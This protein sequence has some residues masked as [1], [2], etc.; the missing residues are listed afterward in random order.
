VTIYNNG[1]GYKDGYRVRSGGA[2]A[3]SA[4]GTVTGFIPVKRGDILSLYPAFE[5]YN[6]NN[7]IN[8][9]D[10]NFVNLGQITDTGQAYG[11]CAG[12][13]ST[14]F[15]SVVGNMSVLNFTDL[16]D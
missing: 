5:N 14:Y 15:T 10:I 3:E 6:T 1:L 2:E 13:T 9:A 7:A 11:I 4:S 16:M 12:K 8:F